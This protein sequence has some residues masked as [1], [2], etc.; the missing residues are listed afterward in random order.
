MFTPRGP[1]I[2]ENIFIIF[3]NK[4]VKGR[5][6][7]RTWKGEW[8]NSW[9]ISTKLFFLVFYF[10]T[11]QRGINVV[12]SC[13]T[14]TR[15]LYLSL[16]LESFLQG[17]PR[18]GEHMGGLEIHGCDNLTAHKLQASCARITRPP[19]F[20]GLARCRLHMAYLFSQV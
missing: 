10:W 9:Q 3:I 17:L 20:T 2:E 1:D 11:C 6:K 19:L 15:V 7:R 14:K 18:R 8:Y 16:D 12:K 13:K 5:K 4:N